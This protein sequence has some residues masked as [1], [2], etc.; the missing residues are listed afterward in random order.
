MLSKIF[1]SF[2]LFTAISYATVK[3]GQPAP[4]FAVKTQEGKPFSLQDRKGKGWTVLFFYPKAG[5]PGC[6]KEACAFR[7]SIKEIRALN[8][9]VYGL[10]ADSVEDQAKFHKEHKLLF[11]LLADPDLKVINAFDV[12][13]LGVN[14]SKRWTYIIDPDLVVRSINEKV[15]PVMDPSNVVAELKKLQAK[16]PANP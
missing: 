2:L 13:M 12:K 8:A 3:I 10:S 15:D 9:E 16:K 4:D 7:D 14:L 5:T 6:T 11:P 1:F